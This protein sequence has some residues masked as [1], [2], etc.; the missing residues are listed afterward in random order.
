[1]I[2]YLFKGEEHSRAAEREDRKCEKPCN[3]PGQNRRR[4]LVPKTSLQPMVKILV[5]LLPC[6]PWKT[7][8]CS[9]GHVCC[10]GRYSQW[11]NR[12]LRT[13]LE[14]RPPWSRF[15][16]KIC[17]PYGGLHRKSLF[18]KDWTLWKGPMLGQLADN[19]SSWEI[20]TLEPSP[21]GGTPH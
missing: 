18:L 11:G 17:D 7:P 6:S 21:M 4:E 19:C 2:P 13:Q 20:P 5:K 3:Y 15:A 8:R 10:E 16:G 14:W 12:L 1:M 9:N